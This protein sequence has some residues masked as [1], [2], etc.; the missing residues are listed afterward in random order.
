MNVGQ[1]EYE[2]ARHLLTEVKGELKRSYSTSMLQSVT[3]QEERYQELLANLIVDY[4]VTTAI[5]FA[6]NIIAMG[7]VLESD[8]P[9][10]YLDDV[11]TNLNE[12]ADN[13]FQPDSYE[14]R[15]AVQ[16]MKE[17]SLL[18]PVGMDE[19]MQ[20]VRREPL[21]QDLPT[22]EQSPAPQ[23]QPEGDQTQAPINQDAQF[24]ADMQEV[25]R[26]EQDAG[27]DTE[28]VEIQ[29]SKS[30]VPLSGLQPDPNV[31]T[32]NTRVISADR[33]PMD[34]YNEQEGIKQEEQQSQAPQGDQLILPDDGG[35]DY[36]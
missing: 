18:A 8:Y 2:Q 34:Y 12:L 11:W 3:F 7:K 10:P 31:S 28:V 5:G 23:H 1:V 21:S 30:G 17:N 15:S 22:A 13:N 27:S 29:M 32:G 26:N 9:P 14:F 16:G 19:N 4:G 36:G 25:F 35:A 6:N 20:P 24:V 33:T